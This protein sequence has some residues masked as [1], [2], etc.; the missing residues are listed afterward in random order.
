M[1][2]RIT[3]LVRAAAVAAIAAMPEPA[4]AQPAGPRAPVATRASIHGGH[5]LGIVKDETGRAI[6]GASVIALGPSSALAK[7]DTQ[8]RFTLS[9][10]PGEY[11]L[12]ASHDLYISTYREPVRI[13]SSV[14]LEREITLWRPGS[15]DDSAGLTAAMAKAG[16]PVTGDAGREH[17]HS[18]AA[19]RLRHLVRTVL[20]DEAANGYKSEDAP[21]SAA[22]M[23]RAGSA[24]NGL[25]QDIDFSGQVNLLTSG[26]VGGPAGWTPDQWPRG[27]AYLAVGAQAGD[28]G[29]WRM[30]A[31]FSGG[32]GRAAAWVLLGELVAHEQAT[33]AYRV[34]ISYGAQGF[35][36]DESR[37]WYGTASTSRGVAGV[38][39]FDSW[40]VR[41]GVTLDYGLRLDR[42]DYLADPELVSPAVGGRVAVLP[43]TALTSQVSRRLVAPGADEFLPPPASGPWMPPERTFSSLIPRAPIRA[44]EVRHYEVGIEHALGPGGDATTLVARRFHQAITDQVATIFGLGA[45]SDLGHYFVATPGTVEVDGWGVGVRQQWRDRIQAGVNYSMIFANWDPHRQARAIR[46]IAPSA[47]RRGYERLHDLTATLAADIPETLTRLTV[48]I[49]ANSGFAHANGGALPV[50]DGRFDVEVHQALPYQPLQGGRLELLFSVRTLSR[51]GRNPGSIY[52]EVLTVAPPLR[53][54]GGFQV[55]F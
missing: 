51:D 6:G 16:Q 3:T 29:D 49:R 48:A 43:R 36:A 40:T 2:K 12:R 38:Y 39:A 42:Y 10:M 23:T 26:S 13:N 22:G 52:D 5:V 35:D 30:R 14:R 46:P 55:R 15:A 44:E 11:I 50:L 54:V 32:Q 1:P 37:P 21:P 33:H 25:L 24:A 27:I 20:R 34:G 17:S 31:A 7:T 18:E 9:L 8:G 4:A 19:W 45:T 53:F 28:F 47:V 41:P